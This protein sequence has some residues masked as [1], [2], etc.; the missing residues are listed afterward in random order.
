VGKKVRIPKEGTLSAGIS[1]PVA[2]CYF[3]LNYDSK[4]TTRTSSYI[5]GILRGSTEDGKIEKSGFHVEFK[6]A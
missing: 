2:L 3:V 1:N 4:Y 6:L 5:N